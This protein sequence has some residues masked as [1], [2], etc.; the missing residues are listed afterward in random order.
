[1]TDQR[2]KGCYGQSIEGLYQICS[3]ETECQSQDSQ[4]EFHFSFC[5][6]SKKKRLDQDF[7]TGCADEHFFDRRCFRY[8]GS[9]CAA[10]CIGGLVFLRLGAGEIPD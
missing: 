10:T 9:L 7:L 2:V 5:E 3:L 6:T 4:H 1:M 8:S